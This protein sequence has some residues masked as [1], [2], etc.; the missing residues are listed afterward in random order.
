M[1]TA[2][3]TKLINTGTSWQHYQNAAYS[4]VNLYAATKQAFEDILTY[5]AEACGFR[6]ITLKLYDTYGPGD[7]RRKV[8]NL[9]LDSALSGETI[10]MSPGDQILDLV[11]VKDVCRA[12]HCAAGLLEEEGR[13]LSVYGI[14]SEEKVTLK[15]LVNL[16]NTVAPRRAK[17]IWGGRPYRAREVMVP[18]SMGASLPRWRAEVSLRDGLLQVVQ[19]RKW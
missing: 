15:E 8:V 16:F 9:L 3:I 4:P 12:Y 11:H 14:A 2:G 17:V 1:R 5:Y 10:E 13:G 6:A 19:Q 7:P 18:W